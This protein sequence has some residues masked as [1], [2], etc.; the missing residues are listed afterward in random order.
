MFDLYFQ[1]R[2][3]PSERILWTGAPKQGLLLTSR[4]IFLVPFSI[5]WCG[6][7]VFWES[8]ALTGDAPL[9]FALWGGMFICIGLYFVFGRLIVDAWARSLTRYAVTDRRI[10]ILRSP[11]FAKFTALDLSQA[12]GIDLSEGANGRGTIRFGRTMPLWGHQGMGIW[13][14]S[15]D[16][17][18]QLLAID[19]ARTVFDMIQKV[20]SV[21]H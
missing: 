5:L 7:A 17:T 1:G 19:D 13:S 16:P 9:F 20:V 4:D 8:Q 3:L 21:N 12:G 18:P 2:L 6:F 10:L 11:P 15:F 14:P